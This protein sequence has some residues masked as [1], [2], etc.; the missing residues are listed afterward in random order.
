MSTHTQHTA[1]YPVLSLSAGPVC[2]AKADLSGLQHHCP[3]L[4]HSL[5]Q[6]LY[7]SNTLCLQSCSLWNSERVA[8]PVS[9]PGLH[10]QVNSEG[11][12]K[13]LTLSAPFAPHSRSGL[14]FL[15]L[16]VLVT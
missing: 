14:P 6:S 3:S 4:V 8:C 15:C 10:L 1:Q 11:P 2:P 7:P 16:D 5:P 12:L 13:P 9:P